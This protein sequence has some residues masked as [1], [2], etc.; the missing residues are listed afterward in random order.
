MEPR[1]AGSMS[2]DQPSENAPAHDN[3]NEKDQLKG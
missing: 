1:S 3:D 2:M